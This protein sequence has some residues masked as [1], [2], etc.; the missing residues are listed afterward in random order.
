M[1]LEVVEHIIRD[2]ESKRNLAINDVIRPYIHVILTRIPKN[3]GSNR[4]GDEMPQNSE[5]LQY[6]MRTPE[7]FDFVFVV[8]LIS[9]CLISAY[10]RHLTLQRVVRLG[11]VDRLQIRVHLYSSV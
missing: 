7:R 5:S 8:H 6:S 1:L 2:R 9:V 4:G 10:S 11:I 3:R